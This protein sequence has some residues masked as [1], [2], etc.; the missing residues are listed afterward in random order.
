MAVLPEPAVP[1][2]PLSGAAAAGPAHGLGRPWVRALRGRRGRPAGVLL[3]A[4]LLGLLLGPEIPGLRNLRHAWFDAYQI[5]APRVR[6]SA[7]AVIVEIDEA[8]LARHGQWPWP[9]TLLARLI[10]TIAGGRPAAIGVDI[11]M[12]E[13]DR[14]SPNRIP[15]LVPGVPRDLAARLARLPSNDTVLAETLRGIPA[16]LG[17][18]GFEGDDAPAAPPGRRT[19]FRVYG[20]DP[21][22]FV[23]RF[24]TLLRSTDEIHGAAAG[25]GLLYGDP[26]AGVVRRLPLVAAVGSVLVPTLGIEML[27]VAGGESA[28]AV[29]VGRRGVEAVAVGD[30]VVPTQPDGTVWIHY[31]PHDAGRFVSA[32]DVLAGTADA[33]QFSRKLV[34]LGVTALGLGDHHATPV[35]PRM[36]G[37]E[38]HAQLLEGIFDGDLLSRPQWSRWAEAAVLA[39]A[40][41]LLILAVPVFPVRRAASLLLLLAAAA[42]GLG[43]LLYR[44]FGVLFDAASPALGL[45]LLFAVMLGVTLAEADRQR[46]ALR[47]QL[48]LEREAAARVA[49]ELEAARRIQ[50]GML[51]DSASAFPRDRRFSVYAF[52]EPA[53]VVGGD[54][55]D[56]FLLD[57]DRLF[58]LIGDVSGKGVPGSLFMAV[59]KALYKST[60]L[61]RTGEIATMMSEA[62]AEIA[63]DNPESLFVTAVAGILN[64]RTGDLEYCIAGHEAPHVLPPG[65]RAVRQLGEG[66]GPPL[67]V[68]DDFPYAA[69]SYRMRP[70]ET[71]CLVTDGITEAMNA[72]G[73]CYGRRRLEGVLEGLEPTATPE[74]VGQA[75]VGDAKRFA[76]GA[77]PSDDLT[78]LVLRWNGPGAAPG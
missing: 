73:E 34:L 46:R 55:Y 56:F 21:F 40:G 14:L 58:F 29:R 19:P 64:A 52:L 15:E 24:A 78:V 62:N 60:A 32:A 39:A 57:G 5:L 41:A 50:M 67:C 63:R 51:P 4:V 74:A 31:T 13:A 17:V 3:L 23:R 36:P 47:G 18:A 77:E 48:A 59:S 1:S 28:F 7:P 30:V 25:H 42:L 66:G 70:G 72:A 53:R 45:G 16:V 68:V 8:S 61:R 11:L 69:A 49:G 33:R 65:G 54:L 2:L 9:R 20:G 71:L 75:V 12:P 35:A 37:V 43:F 6:T 10:A 27:R 44:R 26:D 38:I 76:A 22:L